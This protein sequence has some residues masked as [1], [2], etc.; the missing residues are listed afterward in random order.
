MA[1]IIRMCLRVL[2]QNKHL[3]IT[4]GPLSDTL[5]MEMLNF[6]VKI[7]PIT[8]HDSYSSWRE[9]DH[10]D[11]VLAVALA[12]WAGEEMSVV[13][14]LTGVSLMLNTSQMMPRSIRYIL[15]GFD[16]AYSIAKGKILDFSRY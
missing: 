5:A 12:C 11:L 7:D 4:P 10:D 3:K 9:Q 1:R 14:V 13:Q 16:Q 8:S 6:K 2:L 15:E